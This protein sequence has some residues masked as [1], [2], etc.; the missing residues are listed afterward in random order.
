MWLESCW[1]K[2]LQV[3]FPRYAGHVLLAF[4]E[5]AKLGIRRKEGN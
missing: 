3:L 2:I 5:F 4:E 1:G